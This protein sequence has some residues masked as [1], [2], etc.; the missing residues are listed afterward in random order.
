MGRFN[1]ASIRS[2]TCPTT[3]NP[4]YWLIQERRQNRLLLFRGHQLSTAS[5]TGLMLIIADR[6]PKENE[7]STPAGPM[8]RA[9]NG[10]G[11]L[12]QAQPVNLKEETLIELVVTAP[13]SSLG[14]TSA[15]HLNPIPT[16][17]LVRLISTVFRSHFLLL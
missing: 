13:A 9:A 6:L 5:L 16:S 8:H 2:F 4:R 10:T 12:F 7:V 14:P 1:W 15:E 3:N 17:R 11:R